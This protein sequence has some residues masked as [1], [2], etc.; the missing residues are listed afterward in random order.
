MAST[1]ITAALAVA[2]SSGRRMTVSV[3]RCQKPA[4]WLAGSVDPGRRRRQRT[5]RPS[6]PITVAVR[7]RL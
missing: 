3:Q 2:N 4:R 6:R 7:P 5:A 1:S